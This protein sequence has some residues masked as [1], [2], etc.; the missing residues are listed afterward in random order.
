MSRRARGDRPRSLRRGDRAAPRAPWA[1]A[2]LLPACVVVLGCDRSA[3]AD[4]RLDAS[5]GG[6]AAAPAPDGAARALDGAPAPAAPDA[7]RWRTAPA[8]SGGVLRRTLALD[9]HLMV[10][11]DVG[12]TARRD[13]VMKAILA[14]RGQRVTELQPLAEMEDDD[15]RL[16]EK[17]AALELEKEQASFDR[18]GKL[19]EQDVI[20]DEEYEAIRLRRDA[21][22]KRLQR[23]RYELTKCVIT[24]PFDGVVSGRFVEKGQV[25]KEDDAKVL[26]QV[27]ALRPLLARVYVPEWALFA[28]RRGRPARVVSAM[29]APPASGAAVG[30]GGDVAGVEARVKW[31][32]DVVDAASG[33]VEVLVEI[34]DGPRA[35]DLKPGLSVEVLLELSLEGAPGGGP[36]VTVPRE[37]VAGVGADGPSPGRDATVTVLNGGTTEVRQVTLGFVGDDRV[38]IRRGLAPG[39]VVVLP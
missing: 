39:E 24:A 13:G 29:A 22:E 18:A 26:F 6:G 2:A 4:S 15:L 9:S 20:H 25:I 23:V 34:P 10:E 31:I 16:G 33:T 35:A 1:I 5:P 21:A 7:A 36:L 28:L 38:Q 14:D 8:L 3:S 27:T 17:E 32:N 30:A 37:A 12:V 11:R 19:R